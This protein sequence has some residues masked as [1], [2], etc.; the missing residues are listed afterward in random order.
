ME[1]VEPGEGGEPMTGGGDTT[2]AVTMPVTT[3]YLGSTDAGSTTGTGS[4]SLEIDILSAAAID[5]V[6]AEIARRTAAKAAGGAIKSVTI[7]GPGVIAFLRLH[8]ALQSQLAVLE[9]MADRLA[10]APPAAVET[11]DV[12]GTSALVIPAIGAAAE[13]ARAA[14]GSAAAALSQLAATT[15]YAGRANTARQPVLDAALAKHLAGAGLDVQLPQ[16]A[17]PAK[18]PRGLFARLIA[19]QAKC[20]AL[21]DAG[22]D[23]GGFEPVVRGVD[24]LVSLLFGSSED[25]PGTLPLAQQLM[26]AD[27]VAAGLGKGKAVLLAEIA[28]SGGSYR[29][30]KWIFNFLF[31]KDGLTYNGGAGV[32]FFLYRADDGAT[33]D[34]DTIYF[35]LPHG[36][37]RRE[38]IGEFS[39]TNIT[40]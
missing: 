36:R 13:G 7:A 9:A 15:T 34:S 25:R 35:A 40:G 17:L 39:A 1:A 30:R 16:H 2:Q 12:S 14:V 32:T 31:G 26:L 10:K 20:R 27:G 22:Q 23:V 6:G 38:P 18:E 24:S 29:A 8:S 4:L 19:L 3:D 5:R 21:Q 33:L 37:F 28:F 11:S